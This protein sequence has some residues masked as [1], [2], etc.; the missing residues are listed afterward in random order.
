VTTPDLGIIFSQLVQ[1]VQ[2][3]GNATTM[4]VQWVFSLFHVALPDTY[5]R[6]IVILISGYTLY[7]YGSKLADI[8]VILVLAL[9][10]ATVLGFQLPTSIPG[11]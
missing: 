8:V 4:I 10:A 1:G 9:I 2:H 3:I 5:A 6:I 11:I 7:K